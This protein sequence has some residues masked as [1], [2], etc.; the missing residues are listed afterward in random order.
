M[1]RWARRYPEPR[2]HRSR[3]ADNYR[4][5]VM[6]MPLDGE[7]GRVLGGRYRLLAPIGVGASARVYLADDI[8]LRRQVAVK[9]LHTGLADDARFLRRFRAEAQSAASLNSP[10]VLGV[11]DWGHEEVPFL[12]TEYLGGGSVRSMLDAGRQLTP[13]QA[14]LVGLE[15]ARGLQDAHAHDLVHRDIKPANLLCDENGRLR[16]ADFGLARAIAEAGLTEE[17]SLIGTARY[18]APEQARGE[19][20][21]PAADVYALALTINET[22]TGEVPFD[23]DTV[24][25]TLMARAETPFD[26]DL[27]LGPMVPVLRRAGSLDP[28]DRPSAGELAAALM[29]AASD[30]PRPEP[31][32]LVGVELSE[33]SALDRTEHGTLHTAAVP[34][35]V[36]PLEETTP[37]R[38]WPSV[39]VLIALIGAAV[40]AGVLAW[41]GSQPELVAVPDVVGMS[42]PA[43]VAELADGGFVLE[44]TDVREPG[45]EAG[46]VV[47]TRPGAGVEVEAGDA[48]A[49]FVS[50][51]EPLIG[52]PDVV[53]L[54]MTEAVEQIESAGLVVGVTRRTN[55]ETLPAGQVLERVTPG[56]A[57]ELEPGTPVDLLISD[58]P[59]DRTVPEVPAS[60]SLEESVAVLTELGLAPVESRV[61]SDA[62]PAGAV[63]G[64][65]P[66]PGAIV[67]PGT[68]VSVTVSD[69]PEPRK[70]PAVIGLGVLEAQQVLEAAGFVVVDVQGPPDR[71]VL[72]TDPPAGQI[73]PFGTPV[74]IA[75]SLTAG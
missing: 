35:P 57:A 37:A 47:E 13:S 70:V 53:G 15:A 30:L 33:T 46:E 4:V 36:S 12:V 2:S 54:T 1:W 29:A 24:V 51:G 67:P 72:A 11:F 9:V 23:A 61:Y 25:G 42:R 58:G 62:V 39:L 48:L 74:V 10:H 69:G 56:N 20:V 68:V 52:V 16:I 21:G 26:P 34:G 18:A 14:L 28:D 27:A 64:F 45:T 43:A 3:R 49:V 7:V 55:D 32:P 66:P 5:V 38:R 50:L 22:V 63:I 73:L 8:T 17:G 60:G 71:S 59:A 19:R 40:A 41:R 44:F 31:L 75:T 65:E 6:S